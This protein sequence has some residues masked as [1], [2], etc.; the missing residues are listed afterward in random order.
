MARKPIT[1]KQSEKQNEVVELTQEAKIELIE[2]MKADLPN[3]IQKRKEE[4]VKQLEAYEL[5]EIRDTDIVINKKKLPLMTV[6][7]FAFEPLVLHYG[8]EPKYN[9]AQIS[10]MFDYYRHCIVE[11]NKIELYPPTKEDFCR[12]MGISTEMFKRLKNGYSMEINEVLLQI[13]DYIARWYTQAG[14]TDKIK[15]I[16]GIFYQKSSLGRRDNDPVQINNFTQ[17]NTVVSDSEYQDL[18][19][20]YSSQLNQKDS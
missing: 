3:F 16:T 2:K 20:K 10:L 9:S 14:L 12:L 6:T 18:L 5:A 4:F 1:K 8:T 19:R 7:E 15:E 17:N 11:L 13:E